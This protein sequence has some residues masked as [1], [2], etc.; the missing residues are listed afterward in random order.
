MRESNSQFLLGKQAYYHYTNLA[1]G[2]D[3]RIRTAD[4]CFTKALLYHLS[5]TGLQIN[6]GHYSKL[7]F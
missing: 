5:Y 2:A 6:S 4:L 7:T 3:G 1:Y